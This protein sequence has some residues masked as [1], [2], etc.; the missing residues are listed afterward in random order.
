M[1]STATRI[2]LLTFKTLLISSISTTSFKSQKLYCLRTPILSLFLTKKQW[3]ACEHGARLVIAYKAIYLPEAIDKIFKIEGYLNQHSPTAADEFT[4]M[5]DERVEALTNYPLM[6]QAYDRDPFFRRMVQGDY[7]LF[8][9]VDEKRKLV[10]IHL[11][12]HHTED[13]DQ[14]MRKYRA[15]I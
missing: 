11:I 13:V 4:D 5:L 10:V 12:F 3:H 2:T 15:A 8:Y 6:R 7:I 1:L 14:N 9:S